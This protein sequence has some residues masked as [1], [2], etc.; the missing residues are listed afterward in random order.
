MSCMQAKLIDQNKQD[1]LSRKIGSMRAM[2]DLVGENSSFL[3][4]VP[5]GNPSLRRFGDGARY[6]THGDMQIV[7]EQYDR[8]KK[9]KEKSVKEKKRFCQ[10]CCDFFQQI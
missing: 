1:I 3:I 4:E 10:K 8:S 7:C 9:K 6:I 2:D 5:K